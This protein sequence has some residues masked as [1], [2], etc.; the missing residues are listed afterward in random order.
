MYLTALTLGYAI[1]RSDFDAII[2]SVFHSAVNL[3][4]SNVDLLLTLVAASEDDLPQGIRVD[5]PA[6]FSFE[7]L[8]VASIL[9]YRNDILYLENPPL[10]INLT[11]ARRWRCDLASLRADFCL[12]AVSAA[13][14]FTWQTLNQRQKALGAELVAEDLLRFDES[15]PDG[16]ARRAREAVQN[17]LAAAQGRDAALTP[18]VRALIGLGSGLTPSSDDLLVGFLA[19]L[20]AATRGESAREQFVTDL[21]QTVIQFSPGTNDISRAYLYHAAQGQVSS[22]LADLAGAI[23]QGQGVDRLLGLAEAAMG[24]GHTSGMDAV[25]GLLLGLLAWNPANPPGYP[26]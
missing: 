10:T 6:G 17:L 24:A 23:C 7:N 16:V 20:W 3:L 25:T 13:W 9:R 1:P 26:D 12:P 11:S 5:T 18:A 19:G 14:R 4:P 8:R 21:G 22:R 2:H 15:K